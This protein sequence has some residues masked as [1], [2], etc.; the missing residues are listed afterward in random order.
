MSGWQR[1]ELG[2]RFHSLALSDS[3]HVITST[4]HTILVYATATGELARVLSGHRDQVVSLAVIGDA[5][6]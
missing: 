1:L 4:A 5:V 2:G 3:G 6:F